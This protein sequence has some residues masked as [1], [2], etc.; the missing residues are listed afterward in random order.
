MQR[1]ILDRWQNHF[2][3]HGYCGTAGNYDAT[4]ATSAAEML[5]DLGGLNERI[6]PSD[7]E[8]RLQ[9]ITLSAAGLRESIEALGGRWVHR[10]EEKFILPPVAPSLAW[11]TF[12]TNLRRLFPHEEVRDGQVALIT[13]TH[14]PNSP[15]TTDCMLFARLGKSF[16]MNKTEIGYFL[17]KG[18]DVC[19]YDTRGVL[20]SAGYP[21]EAGLYNDIDAVGDHLFRTYD[22]AR[23]CIYA[24]CGESFTATHLFTRYHARGISMLLENAP[25]SLENVMSRINWIAQQMF[26][27]CSS[28]IQAPPT[29]RCHS[30]EEDLFNSA[31]KIQALPRSDSAGR[32]TL[33][34]TTGDDMAPGP[35]VDAMAASLRQTGCT[36]TVLTNT[37][38]DDLED[39]H[40]ANPL[41]NPLIDQRVTT[42]L[43]T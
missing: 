7:G 16:V 5:V 28:C 14:T 41:R 18:I 2:S 20:N 11:T 9:M 32:V 24:T 12:Y 22:P 8:A 38:P 26:L 6:T 13:A 37:P 23:V 40:L 21:S 34:K 1:Y 39:P 33:L 36:V 43:F 35:E 31:A 3:G 19:V 15:R 4:R 17:G 25:A 10:G 29:S 30:T 42:S 27:W